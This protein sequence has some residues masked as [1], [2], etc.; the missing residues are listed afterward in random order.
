MALTVTDGQ[1]GDMSHSRRPPTAPSLRQRARRLAEAATT[2]LVPADFL[3][4]FAPAARR[5]RPAR[6]DRRRSEPETRDAATI[7]HQARR[8]LGRPRARPV[9]PDRHR[10]RRRPPVA[11]LLAHPRPPRRRA[12]LDHRQGGAR[13][14]GQ[15][16][17]RPRGAARHAGPPRAGRRRVRARRA[18][19]ASCSS[20][21]PAP[22]SP[23]SSGCCA[24][25][26]PSPTAAS[27]RLA[28]SRDLDI[29]VVHVAPSEPDSIFPR[30]LKALD[31]AG[32]I[33]LVARYDDQ[34][35]VA[36]RRRP[37][38]RWCPT[39]PSAPR[40]L[41]PGRPARRARGAPRRARA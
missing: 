1:D 17:P 5:R 40:R 28:R 6:P 10:R 19:A 23:R 7:V 9:R 20:S 27:L 35:G 3:D 2:P 16:P 18:A 37:G 34:H 15:Q 21:P 29:V 8:R 38:G 13:R 14:Q 32:A 26:S 31:A 33:R 12:D 24:T 39:S 25:C 41:R 36:R 11:R 4:L 22:A 30:D